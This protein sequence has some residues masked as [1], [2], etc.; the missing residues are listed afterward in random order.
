MVTMEEKNVI[1][2]DVLC[3]WSVAL[4]SIIFGSSSSDFHF[5]CWPLRVNLT[6]PD[7]NAKDTENADY[8]YPIPETTT[9]HSP[10]ILTK[11][12]KHEG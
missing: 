1:D 7:P 2:Y 11:T 4:L 5:I 12:I 6:I 3:E 8:R 9:R 10:R